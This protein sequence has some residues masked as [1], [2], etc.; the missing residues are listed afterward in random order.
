MGLLDHMFDNDW[1]QRQDIEALKAQSRRLGR[2]RR[3]VT[4]NLRARV[5]E[6]EDT[7]GGLTLL[8]RGLLEMME[9]KGVWNEEEFR[10]ICR[11]ID[12]ADGTLDGKAPL[13]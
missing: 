5:E 7:V 10:A 6:L 8:C 2:S 1:R 4:A 11:E 9:K 3:K 13:D 12:A